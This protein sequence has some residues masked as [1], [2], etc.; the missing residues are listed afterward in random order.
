[1]NLQLCQ[2]STQSQL[3][4][5]QPPFSSH[6]IGKQRVCFYCGKPGHQK[7]NCKLKKKKRLEGELGFR[8]EFQVKQE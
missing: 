4:V 8:P 1:M 6:L 3:K 2:L 5:N 7:M